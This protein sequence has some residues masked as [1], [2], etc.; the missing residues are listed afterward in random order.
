MTKR[1]FPLTTTICVGAGFAVPVYDPIR[2]F[3]RA[4]KDRWPPCSLDDT[5]FLR[6]MVAAD[7]ATRQGRFQQAEEHFTLAVAEA[8]KFGGLRLADSLSA[9]G[10]A[11]QRLDKLTEARLYFTRSRSVFEKT[12][13]K[14][15]SGVGQCLH[16]LALNSQREGRW[17][18][19]ESLYLNG[20]AIL[21]KSWGKD[22]HPQV[23]N[24]L[25]SLAELYNQLGRPKDAEAF[26]RRSLAIKEK[27][28]GPNDPETARSWHC[29]ANI[30]TAQK[31]H[32][33]AQSLYERALVVMRQALGPKHPMVLS[34]QHELAIIY[35]I[36]KQYDLA[37][38]LARAAFCGREQALGANHAATIQALGTLAAV[39]LNQGKL[40]E[41]EPLFRRALESLENRFPDDHP[42]KAFTLDNYATLLRLTGRGRQAK[43][44]KAAAKALRAQ[45]ASS[46]RADR[47]SFN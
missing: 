36:F 6:H 5:L 23:S 19:A 9:L 16:N 3:A 17:A 35:A 2:E 46:E 42:D 45:H 13:G 27:V 21:E 24:V 28:L 34:C 47:A 20:L 25:N 41:A 15:H 33:E 32:A 18:E 12:G 40:A 43:R 11:C 37:E 22:K 31:R 44:Y 10:G 7:M 29:L 38:R 1:E 4:N 26:C 8:E 14:E 30:F 39:L